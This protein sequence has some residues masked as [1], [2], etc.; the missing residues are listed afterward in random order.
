MPYPRLS[1]AAKLSRSLAAT[2]MLAGVALSR[3]ANAP[4]QTE[5]TIYNFGTT[6]PNTPI[7]GLV[8]DKSGNLY[9]V[10]P[11]GGSGS[12]GVVYKLTPVSGGWQQ[13]VIYS[14]PAEPTVDIP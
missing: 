2:F 1:P 9:G 6:A 10:T 4:A 3:A 8:L 12:H 14:L 5:T 7:S 13:S 11:Y